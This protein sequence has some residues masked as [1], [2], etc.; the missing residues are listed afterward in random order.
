MAELKDKVQKRA[1]PSEETSRLAATPF[2]S[3]APGA[4]APA[5]APEQ[6]VGVLAVAFFSLLVGWVL[7]AAFSRRRSR[8]QRGRLRL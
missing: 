3:D 4:A 2:A 6:G 5:P 8:S 7:G 1:G